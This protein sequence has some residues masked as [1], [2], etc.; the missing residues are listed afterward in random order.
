MKKENEKIN[1]AIPLT[2]TAITVIV[3]AAVM[4]LFAFIM[5]VAQIDSKYSPVLA[6][7]SLAAGTFAAAFY[8][9]RKIGKR[10]LFIGFVTGLAVFIFLTII[11]MIVDKGSLSYNTLFHFVILMLSSFIGG[12]MGVNKKSKR[13]YI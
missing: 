2:A 6:T 13:N 10:G 11:S 4:A 5:Y 7:V 3:T 1:A 8:A 12:V 9:A